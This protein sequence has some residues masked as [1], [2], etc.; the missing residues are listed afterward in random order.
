MDGLDE[1]LGC[2]LKPPLV[3]LERRCLSL[4]LVWPVHAQL[5]LLSLGWW[6][7]HILEVFRLRMLVLRQDLIDFA[8]CFRQTGLDVVDDSL[9]ALN[10]PVVLLLSVEAVGFL[11]LS[12]SLAGL[13][14]IV[15]ARGHENYK[16]QISGQKSERI[17]ILVEIIIL[18]FI[19]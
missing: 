12:F 2:L 14:H 10:L 8:Y 6:L 3:L 7:E 19:K 13:F 5:D 18:R 9:R 4:R 11:G 16:I 17:L 15:E 1:C